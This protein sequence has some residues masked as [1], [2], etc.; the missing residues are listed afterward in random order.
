MPEICIL[1]LSGFPAS[2][3]STFAKAICDHFN[4]LADYVCYHVCYDAI[5]SSDI[6]LKLLEL[7]GVADHSVSKH[8]II[9]PYH[10]ALGLS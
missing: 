7:R 10:F 3:K 1:V 9:L 8:S 6:E 4:Q 2:G 5:L